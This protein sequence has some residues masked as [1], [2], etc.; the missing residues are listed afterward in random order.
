M[1]NSIKEDIA[2]LRSEVRQ[3][4]KIED[5]KLE[6][7]SSPIAGA[8]FGGNFWTQNSMPWVSQDGRKAV[9]TEWFW[10]NFTHQESNLLMHNPEFRL[11]SLRGQDRSVTKLYARTTDKGI[12]RMEIQSGLKI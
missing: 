1:K 9:L 10:Q 2:R 4:A 3:L 12:L 11:K 5:V 8:Q 7:A 6:K